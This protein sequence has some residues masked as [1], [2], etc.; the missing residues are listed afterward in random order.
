MRKL[1]I[2]SLKFDE[3]GLVPVIAQDSQSNEVLMLAYSSAAN[4]MESVEL[5]K[6]VFFSR[7]RQERWLKG[8]T[9]GNYLNIVELFQ[10]CDSDT[11][12]ARVRP[13]GPACHNGTKTCF[14]D[15]QDV[16]S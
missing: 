14:E 3:H 2:A 6:L 15:R 16:K 10:D 4:L 5:G 13:E 11:V 9:S 7:S 1:E 8:E 12:L